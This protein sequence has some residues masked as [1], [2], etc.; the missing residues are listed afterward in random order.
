MNVIKTFILVAGL[1]FSLLVGAAQAV[2]INTADAAT[3]SKVLNGIG[4]ARAEAIVAYRKK[5]GPFKSIDDLAKVSGVGSRTVAKN[6]D[7]LVVK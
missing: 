7:K 4:E 3:L 6:R 1:C 5:N 2:N